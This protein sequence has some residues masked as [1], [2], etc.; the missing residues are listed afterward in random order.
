MSKVSLSPNCLNC[1]HPI[2]K[3]EVYCGSCGQKHHDGKYSVGEV[4][5]EFISS[6]FNLDAKIFRTLYGLMKPGFLTKEYFLGAHKRYYKPIRLFLTIA[7]IAFAFMQPNI[8]GDSE[9]V[10]ELKDIRQE[11]K[12]RLEW[13]TLR[14]SI[15]SY[16]SDDLLNRRLDTLTLVGNSKKDEF[17][18]VSS[19]VPSDST[20]KKSDG[21]FHLTVGNGSLF[22]SG[23][24][25]S[26]TL[27]KYKFSSFELIDNT[28][29]Q[30]VDKYFI[31]EPWYK[32]MFF[33]QLLKSIVDGSGMLASL[34]SKLP[35]L[36]LI[37][38]PL[39]ALLF[40]F[41]YL[42]RKRYFVEHFVFSLH[43]NSFAL[44]LAFTIYLIQLIF[45]MPEWFPAIFA[46]IY[47]IYYYLA[48]KSYYEQGW[49]KTLLK[50]T[51]ANFLGIFVGT[52]GLI[53]VLALGMLFY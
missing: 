19:K 18:L 49:F 35:I 11:E 3:G 26:T 41:L 16:S 9:L 39:Y 38:T 44:L 22:S 30:I 45:K 42:R 31:D 28:P 8:Q 50:F 33:R 27:G 6:T 37:I 13:D 21:S 24:S 2:P 14:S 47:F 51:L 43:L 29:Q 25:D 15:Q 34:S 53:L 23:V 7:V 40:F 48:M 20:S 5:S 17:D 32:K 1:E 52:F 10:S 36:L 12:L 4:I 46:S